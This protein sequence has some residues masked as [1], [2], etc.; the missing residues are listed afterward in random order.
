MAK[1]STTAQHFL[2]CEECEENPAKYFCKTCAG[3][4]CELCKNIHERKKITKN[5]EILPVVNQFVQIAS[6]NLITDIL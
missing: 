1:A 4:L 6:C 2:E 3:H 5:H